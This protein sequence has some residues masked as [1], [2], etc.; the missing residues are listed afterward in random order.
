M[1]WQNPGQYRPEP[2]Y[3]VMKP[4]M[5]CKIIDYKSIFFV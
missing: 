1:E 5:S 4:N 3:Y 2:E